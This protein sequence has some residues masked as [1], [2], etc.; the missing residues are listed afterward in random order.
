VSI[1]APAGAELTCRA[2]NYTFDGVERGVLSYYA[3][4]TLPAA[5][6][7]AEWA[8]AINAQAEADVSAGRLPFRHRPTVAAWAGGRK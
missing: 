2:L 8:A 3:A 1:A 6:G 7:L 5:P 4:R